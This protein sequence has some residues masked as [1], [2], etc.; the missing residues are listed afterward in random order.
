MPSS[1]MPMSTIEMEAMLQGSVMQP[2]LNP[3]W[4]A[5]FGQW[6]PHGYV[7]D[8]TVTPILYVVKCG[9]DMSI[10][11]HANSDQD[12]INLKVLIG[13][14]FMAIQYDEAAM[15][16][17]VD[18]PQLFKTIWFDHSV[19]IYVDWVNNEVALNHYTMRDIANTESMASIFYRFFMGNNCHG[20][21]DKYYQSTM[22]EATTN[23][24]AQQ[25]SPSTQTT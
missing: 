9:E 2:S 14:V 10:E 15:L 22:Q 7:W 25:E 1:K 17:H 8:E 13:N 11:L 16:A 18:Q 19:A 3:Q 21:V 20:L 24:S 6:Q 5:C 12:A 4:T 23:A